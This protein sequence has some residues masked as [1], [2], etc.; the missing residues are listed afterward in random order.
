MT[1]TVCPLYIATEVLGDPNAIES[2]S[3]NA[4]NFV[5]LFSTYAFDCV[6]YLYVYTQVKSSQVAFNK[7]TWQS[8]E[9]YKQVKWK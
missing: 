8:H 2:F 3:E 9:F 7:N 5:E 4:E 1:A 6:C